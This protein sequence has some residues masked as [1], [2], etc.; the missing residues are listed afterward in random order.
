MGGAPG[1]GFGRRP[2]KD[3]FSRGE[4]VTRTGAAGSSWGWTRARKPCW[5]GL[6]AAGSAPHIVVPACDLRARCQPPPARTRSV[7]G[8]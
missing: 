6:V 4:G 1:P 8:N 5:G 3:A 2:W 7:L